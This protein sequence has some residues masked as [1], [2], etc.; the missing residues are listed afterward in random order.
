MRVKS[1]GLQIALTL[2]IGCAAIF[3]AGVHAQSAATAAQTGKKELTFERL[4]S[5]RRLAGRLVQGMSGLR[6]ASA[7]RTS[8]GKASRWSFGPWT[9]RQARR[10]SW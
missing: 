3:P 5:A 7:S 4:F 1:S 9:R 6:M 8:T 10:K 2:M